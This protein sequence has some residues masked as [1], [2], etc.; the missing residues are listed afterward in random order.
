MGRQARAE[1][2]VGATG[3]LK[4]AAQAPINGAPMTVRPQKMAANPKSNERTMC[5]ST[6]LANGTLAKRGPG[7]TETGPLAKQ[8]RNGVQ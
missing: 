6:P 1:V 4:L 2:P 7:Q 3:N 8:A 5:T